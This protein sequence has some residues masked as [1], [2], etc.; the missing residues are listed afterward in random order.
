MTYCVAMSLDAGMIFAS[1]SRTNAGVDQIARFSKMRIFTRDGDRVIVTLS[2]GNLSIT[3]NALSIIDQRARRADGE[4]NLW[5]AT[6]MFDVARLTGD[7]LR[8]ARRA[9]RPLADAVPSA[10]AATVS[11]TA[12]TDAVDTRP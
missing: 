1:D 12:E 4:L 5:N 7:A 2:S 8:S 6:S 11:A 3:Q 9:G 10:R